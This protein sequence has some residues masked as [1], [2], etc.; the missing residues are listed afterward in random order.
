MITNTVRKNTLTAKQQGHVDA[1]LRAF[2][3]VARADAKTYATRRDYSGWIRRF[4]TWAYLVASPELRDIA[5]P[6]AEKIRG[7][8][9]YIAAGEDN[10]RRK[11]ATCIWQARHALI[12]FYLKV[13]RIE[14][15]DI[16]VIPSAT[17]HQLVK[18]VRTPEEV[19]RVINAV[20]DT[21]HTP[22][23]LILSLLYYTG[24][25][26]NDVLRLRLKDIDWA[27]SEVVFRAGKGR[28]DRR[29]RLPCAAMPA[30]RTQMAYAR[31]LHA[32]DQAQRPPVPV[33]LPEPVYNKA[34][35]WGFAPGWYF[36]FPAPSVGINPDTQIRNRWHTNPKDVQRATRAAADRTEL[37]GVLTPHKLRHVYATE[38][39]RDGVDI[40]SVQELLGH[41]DV[42]TTE[43]YTHTA[44]RSDRTVQAIERHA[45]RLTPTP[46]AVA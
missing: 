18:D 36:L 24:G 29:V 13:R 19:T 46:E 10:G 14:V 8:L 9:L 2:D 44:I 16:G 40:R 34:P 7:F 11:S 12:F 30:L 32:F 1:A 28:K 33:E 42:K 43:T 45:L 26:I 41:A 39:L 15:G 37:T 4:C 31:R 22:Y 38:L 20:V 35:S 27:N 3:A 23:R 17:R 5:T 25:R 6:P 21:P